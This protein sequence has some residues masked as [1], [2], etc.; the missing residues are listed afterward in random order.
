MH[1][2]VIA[3]YCPGVLP[4]DCPSIRARPGHSLVPLHCE[5]HVGYVHSAT[6]SR[7]HVQHSLA[8]GREIGAHIK[9]VPPYQGLGAIRARR[10]S[11]VY[12]LL[13]VLGQDPLRYELQPPTPAHLAVRQHQEL[14]IIGIS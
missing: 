10:L 12:R 8:R 11:I 4:L 1:A 6:L 13:G 7:L 5:T 3:K 2:R 14:D 9:G